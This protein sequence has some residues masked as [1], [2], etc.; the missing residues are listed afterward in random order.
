MTEFCIFYIK[1]CVE[2]VTCK[3]VILYTEEERNGQ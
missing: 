2:I 1:N 3:D